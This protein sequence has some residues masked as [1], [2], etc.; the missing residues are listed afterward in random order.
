[1]LL[2]WTMLPIASMYFS[3]PQGLGG[4]GKCF[5]FGKHLWISDM[6]KSDFDYCERS[7]MA[8]YARI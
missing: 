5:A 8:K 1:M 2:G 4:L 6:F 3:F 7:F